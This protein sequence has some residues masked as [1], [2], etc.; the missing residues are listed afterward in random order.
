MKRSRVLCGICLLAIAGRAELRFSEAG[1]AFSFDTGMLRGVL[2]SQGKSMGIGPVTEC[3]TGVNITGSLGLFSHYRLLDA[4][5]RYLPDAR[6]WPSQ[7]R[8]LPDGAVEM[9]W[10]ADAQHPFDLLAVYA[11][12]SS[13]ALDVTTT[14]TA[15]QPLRRFEVFMASYFMGFPAAYG[16]G[17]DGF[18]EA[19]KELGDWLS[20]PRDDAAA[21][22]IADGRWLWPPNPVTFK[23]VARYAG[24]LGL[25]RD[26][27]SGL[28]GVVMAPPEECF[29]VL[30]PYG[31][32]GHRSLYLS[33]FGRDVR[34][35][36]AAT[37]RARLVIC[38]NLSDGQAV[39]MYQA[40]LKEMKQR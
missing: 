27:A 21:A 19:K 28:A 14:V 10:Q 36:E 11:W 39:R 22:L 32:E 7:A 37:A 18:V 29:A 16:Y 23:P 33:L 31:E 6:N 4:E 25:R 15:R 35:G 17:A 24:A 34:A 12:T 30:M 1:N 13:N 40:Y 20:F 26:A 3:G 8:L 2:R 38:R 9:R 5:R